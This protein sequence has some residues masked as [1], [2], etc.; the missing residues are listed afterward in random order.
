MKSQY[1]EEQLSN[2]SIFHQHL[3]SIFE[4]IVES[5]SVINNLFFNNETSKD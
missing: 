2:H 4:R 5:V 1:F 3:R